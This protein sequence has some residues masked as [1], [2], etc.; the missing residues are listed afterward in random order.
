MSKI[1]NGQIIETAVEARG[2]ERGP[3][4]RN[5]LV[6]SI[7]LAVVALAVVSVVFLR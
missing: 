5:V 2:A 7:L 4:I 6:I 3:T 1:E